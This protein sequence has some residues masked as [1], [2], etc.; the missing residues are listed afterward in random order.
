MLLKMMVM[1]KLVAAVVWRMVLGGLLVLIL[2]MIRFV[3]SG[4]LQRS[5][6]TGIITNEVAAVVVLLVWVSVW[7]QRPLAMVM[8]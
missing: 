5:S 7:R 3:D 8:R 1:M 6:T 2:N 4:I